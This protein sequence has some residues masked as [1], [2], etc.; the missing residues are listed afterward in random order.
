MRV[1]ES[2]NNPSATVYVLI[3]SFSACV[4]TIANANNS[5][6][7]TQARRF[8]V[9]DSET[10]SELRNSRIITLTRPHLQEFLLSIIRPAAFLF[11]AFY[12]SI[13]KTSF[14]SISIFK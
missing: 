2:R 9:Q 3:G 14:G 8:V 12:F 4:G 6:L 11:T 5:P 13:A 10:I 7:K 1:M